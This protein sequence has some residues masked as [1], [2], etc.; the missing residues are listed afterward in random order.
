M[1]TDRLF[2]IAFRLGVEFQTM[3][4]E[5]SFPFP[6]SPDTPL[7]GIRGTKGNADGALG[8]RPADGPLDAWGLV[9][10]MEKSL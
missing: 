2:M 3:G 4:H 6:S 5:G 10:M 9:P 7:V 8:R 1:M